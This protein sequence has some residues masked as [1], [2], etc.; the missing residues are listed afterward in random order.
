MSATGY[1]TVLLDLDHTLFDS[2]ASE[3]AAFEVTMAAFGASD[4]GRHRE[5]YDRINR[6]LWRRVEAGEVGPD[7][8]KLARFDQ[9]VATLALDADPAAMAE[10]FAEALGAHGDLYPGAVEVLEQLAQVASLALVTN[11]LS[12]VQRARI[13]RHRLDDLFDAIVIS[14]E[15]GHSKPGREIFDLTF[16]RLGQPSRRSA[17]MVGD[18]LSSDIRGGTAYGIDT[19]WYNPHGRPAGSADRFTHQISRLEQL[20]TLV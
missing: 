20:P 15:V 19:C 4:P 11:G 2:D 3:N 12:E 17:L 13:E 5:A 14:A 10:T 8:V 9:L 6:S 7:Y 1:S 16:E 18:S